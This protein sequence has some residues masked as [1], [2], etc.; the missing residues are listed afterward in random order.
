MDNQVDSEG[1]TAGTTALEIASVRQRISAGLVDAVIGILIGVVGGALG[2]VIGGAAGW[3]LVFMLVIAY[4]VVYLWLVSTRG[5][6]PGKMAIGIKIV[7]M[8]GSAIGIGG[9]LIREIIGKLVS[10]I[11]YLGYIWI[12]F[13]GKRQG[14]HD[15][16]AG[17]IVVRA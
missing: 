14:W 10:S 13:D 6:S 1:S 7:K 3:L 8:D 5:Q 17:T 11:F 15:K 12:L 2:S 16:I 4:V 9:A